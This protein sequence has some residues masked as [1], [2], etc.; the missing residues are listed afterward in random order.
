[1]GHQGAEHGAD[2]GQCAQADQCAG[3]QHQPGEHHDDG[4]HGCGEVGHGEGCRF[5]QGFHGHGAGEVHETEHQQ[6]AAG[7]D[8]WEQGER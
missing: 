7:E 3:E 4:G 6:R 8:P 2:C 1:M 5:D